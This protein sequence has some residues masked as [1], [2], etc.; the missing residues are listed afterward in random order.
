MSSARLLSIRPGRVTLRQLGMAALVGGGIAA[1]ANVALFLISSAL[2]TSFVIP[3]MGEGSPPQ[4]LPTFFVIVASVLPAFAAA[5]FLAVLDRLFAQ[6]LR[7][8]QL[9]GW[10]AA[11]LS[12]GGPLTLPVALTTRLVLSSMHIIAAAAIIGALSRAARANQGVQRF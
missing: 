5:A 9:I 10:L 2:G 11:L 4:Q 8:F 3:L 7:W 12:L 6:P 1:I